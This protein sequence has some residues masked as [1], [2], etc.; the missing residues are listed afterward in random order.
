MRSNKLDRMFRT[1]ISGFFR[2]RVDFFL[3][4][5]LVALHRRCELIKS[6]LD[7]RI[8]VI[9]IITLLSTPRELDLVKSTLTR[10]FPLCY[11]ETDLI[12]LFTI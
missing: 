9:V 12:S 7:S 1:E 10:S 6:P 3:F 4:F 8:N 2:R 11:L 5:F